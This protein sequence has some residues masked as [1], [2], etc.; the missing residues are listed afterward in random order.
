MERP[1]EIRIRRDQE[2]ALSKLPSRVQT[3]FWSLIEDLRAHGSHPRGWPAIIKLLGDDYRCQ[4]D[5]HWICAWS[6]RGSILELRAPRHY[7]GR[8]ETLK[9]RP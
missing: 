5:A 7:V 4:L 3:K 6:A 2:A 8:L 1:Y 9:D